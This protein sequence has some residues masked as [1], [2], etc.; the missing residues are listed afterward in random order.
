M[1]PPFLTLPLS[2]ETAVSDPSV[3]L[4]YLDISC[5]FHR[6]S[7]A[8]RS[9]IEG[10]AGKVFLPMR[11]CA[12]DHGLRPHRIMKRRR[13][14]GDATYRSERVGPGDRYESRRERLARM[15]RTSAAT[16]PGI[17]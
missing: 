11:A 16:S 1:Y 6:L 8:Y 10:W 17:Q 3:R 2:L 5:L 7:L 12:D 13:L 14:S 9:M 15:R 4:V